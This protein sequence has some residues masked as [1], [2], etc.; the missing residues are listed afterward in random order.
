MNSLFRRRA[1]ADRRPGAGSADFMFT[2]ALPV[3]GETV[4]FTVVNPL[5]GVTYTWDRTA[6]GIIDYTGNSFS[7]AYTS[8]GNKT[9]ALY[10]NGV[11]LVEKTFTVS[12]A[13]T[14]PGAGV[15]ALHTHRLVVNSGGTDS[16]DNN[17]NHLDFAYAYFN[18]RWAYD[19][20]GISSIVWAPGHLYEARNLWFL[21]S[22][23][24]VA[25]GYPGRMLNFHNHPAFGGWIPAGG[26]D[27]SALA[28]DWHG[29]ASYSGYEGDGTPTPVTGLILQM[30]HNGAIRGFK[31]RQIFSNAQMLAKQ[32]GTEWI[33]IV[34]QVYIHPSAGSIKLWVNGADTPVVDINPAGTCWDNQTGFLM[35]EGIYGGAN[36]LPSQQTHEFTP[37]RHGRTLAEA[38][39]CGTTDPITET[40]VG[41]SDQYYEGPPN[42]THTVITSRNASQFRLPVSL[43]GSG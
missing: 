11:L 17:G 23:R 36:W 19:Y 29:S 15:G 18:R 12:P 2:P 6:D 34:G 7:Y 35:Y 40:G 30:E 22:F 8:E 3:N 24:P 32:G 28:L 33:D 41:G 21:W 13:G 1:I 20:G 42:Y 14:P 37:M 10:G 38:I 43:G 27:D 26:G 39:A 4:T 5:P 25:G 9:V 16:S 31:K